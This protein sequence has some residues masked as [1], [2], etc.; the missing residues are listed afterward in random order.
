MLLYTSK[1]P[2][3]QTRNARKVDVKNVLSVNSFSA[4]TTTAAD[5]RTLKMV[6]QARNVLKTR[7]TSGIASTA[8]STWEQTPPCKARVS[9]DE[10]ATSR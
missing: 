5:R 10:A 4:L 6:K 1:R 7:V 2:G 9:A 8:Q 3:M